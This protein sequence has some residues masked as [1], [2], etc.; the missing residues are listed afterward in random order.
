MTHETTFIHHFVPASGEGASPRLLLLLHGTGGDENDLLD[1]GRELDGDAA[2]LSPRGRVLEQGMPR[3]FRRIAPG[4]FDLEDL[5]L[6]AHELADFVEREAT[7]RGFP[8]GRRL[9]VGLSNGANI[10]AA[11]LLLRPAVLAGAV[12]LRPMV[13]LVPEKMPDLAR[14]SALVMAGRR[15]PLVPAGESERLAA[16]LRDAG[17]DVTLHW[18]DTGHALDPS[19][20]PVIRAW[21]RDPERTGEA[22]R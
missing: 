9:A 20:P 22:N 13:P 7:R 17:A 21:L 19:E 1:L 18:T 14:V 2:L 3:Y 4:R 16:L 6:R 10:A 12:L 8:S 11:M 5:I 15:D